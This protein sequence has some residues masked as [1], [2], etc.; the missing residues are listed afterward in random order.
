M[1]IIGLATLGS[2]LYGSALA[3]LSMRCYAMQHEILKGSNHKAALGVGGL[4]AVMGSLL[5]ATIN[6]SFPG[7]AASSVLISRLSYLLYSYP[8]LAGFAGGGYAHLKEV[9]GN[10]PAP[11]LRAVVKNM[12][13]L[14]S[15]IPEPFFSL[16]N[17]FLTFSYRR[18][19]NLYLGLQIAGFG[20]LTATV[21]PILGLVG[22]SY[23]AL[24]FARAR[25]YLPAYI[26]TPMEKFNY[27]IGLFSGVF[28]KNTVLKFAAVLNLGYEFLFNIGMPKLFKHYMGKDSEFLQITEMTEVQKFEPRIRRDISLAQFKEL[29]GLLPPTKSIKSAQS[30]KKR[31]DLLR[32][33]LGQLQDIA[34]NYLD[35]FAPPEEAKKALIAHLQAQEKLQQRLKEPGLFTWLKYKKE[36]ARNYA[37]DAYIN[38]KYAFPYVGK[39]F[40]AQAA[41]Q[42]YAVTVGHMA[43][44]P[45]FLPPAPSVD[46]KHLQSEVA[47]SFASNSAQLARLLRARCLESPKF[48]EID[49]GISHTLVALKNEKNNLMLERVRLNEAI[50]DG[51]GFNIAEMDAA[52]RRRDAINARLP[53]L[54]KD[55]NAC[56]ARLNTAWIKELSLPADASAGDVYIAYAKKRLAD[57]CH[58]IATGEDMLWDKSAA[59]LDQFQEIGRHLLYYCQRLLN[60]RNQ[61]KIEKAHSILLEVAI[62]GGDFCANGIYDVVKELF[63]RHVMPELI[64]THAKDLTAE[65]KLAIYLQ[66]ER[67][68]L[69]DEI[70]GFFK[71]H[72]FVKQLFPGINFDDRHTYSSIMRALA[73]LNLKVK[74]NSQS[75]LSN[76]QMAFLAQLEM[77]FE[78]YLMARTLMILEHGYTAENIVER[79]MRENNEGSGAIAFKAGVC[80]TEWARNFHDPEVREYIEDLLLESGTESDAGRKQLYTMMLYDLGVITCMV[81]APQHKI[82]AICPIAKKPTPAPSFVPGF[83]SSMARGAMEI[84]AAT[85]Y[86]AYEAFTEVTQPESEEELRRSAELANCRVWF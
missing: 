4:Q 10:S 74:F 1:A 84:T 18:I 24:S 72:P 6:L 59:S 63:S 67:Q 73:A 70:Y 69:I 51:F 22:L 36:D 14:L 80:A 15:Y 45:N 79:M 65:D 17:R 78:A 62:E 32:E 66:E 33:E 27:W 39:F 85:G 11:V 16:A 12:D 46:Y 44:V 48:P 2:A 29:F 49:E 37:Y 81:E 35:E 7:A 53:E 82:E 34:F 38:L 76:N 8:V 21:Q 75:D 64:Q 52:Y 13:N 20:L 50:D 83:I 3:V 68:I 47:N 40:D 5:I 54:E 28:L 61:E 30:H 9:W 42:N 23:S 26:A 43:R 56:Y 58:K 57:A 55:I 41:K 31:I 60:S 25:N 86:R 19:G 77:H 71:E